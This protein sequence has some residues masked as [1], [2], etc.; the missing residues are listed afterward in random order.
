LT[1]AFFDYSNPVSLFLAST[2][3]GRLER[4]VEPT[5][6]KRKLDFKSLASFDNIHSIKKC[7]V[8]NKRIFY[9]STS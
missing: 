5:L 3:S 9:E 1:E 6:S 7:Y 2:T 4:G 8:P